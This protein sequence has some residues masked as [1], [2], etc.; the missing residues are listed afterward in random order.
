M[1]CVLM[2]GIQI[3]EG[4]EFEGIYTLKKITFLLGFNSAHFPLNDRNWTQRWTELLVLSVQLAEDSMNEWMNLVR[5]MSTLFSWIL[6]SAGGTFVQLVSFLKD[7]ETF[8]Y[9]PFKFTAGLKRGRKSELINGWN[10]GSIWRV[11]AEVN[12]SRVS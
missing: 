9:S 12:P 4:S 8:E 10:M 2:R 7:Y 3:T 1:E 6:Q 11:E 5:N